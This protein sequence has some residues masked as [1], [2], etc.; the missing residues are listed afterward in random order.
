MDC[1]S[2]VSESE[3]ILTGQNQGLTIVAY[4]IPP[5]HLPYTYSSAS[6]H[7]P[8]PDAG[9]RPAY[10]TPRPS[11]HRPVSPISRPDAPTNG[12]PVFA[13]PVP[14]PGAP[15]GRPS[16]HAPR[17]PRPRAHA[18]RP[19]PATNHSPQKGRRAPSAPSL[20]RLPYTY[21][22]AGRGPPP[23]HATPAQVHPAY[24][25]PPRGRGGASACPTSRPSGHLSLVLSP[26]PPASGGGVAGEIEAKDGLPSADRNNKATLLLTGP[27]RTAKS[28]AK[29]LTPLVL[30]LQY[31]NYRGALRAPRRNR[32]LR[33]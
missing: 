23:R 32:L 25:V 19:S 9:V 31:A 7:P 22:V 1:D 11:P 18:A 17:R 2:S 29:D 33:R 5:L 28:S 21:T 8:L 4:P 24:P 10:P 14:A 13:Y 3:R 16:T 15:W 27:F 6:R 26:A 30:K 12:A 20:A